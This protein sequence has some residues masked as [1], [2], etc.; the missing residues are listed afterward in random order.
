[1]RGGGFRL[2]R[3]GFFVSADGPVVPLHGGVYV[4]Q[5]EA[6]AILLGIQLQRQLVIVFGLPVFG[7]LGLEEGVS[8]LQ[9]VP[10]GSPVQFLK[11]GLL[12]LIRGGNWIA[13]ACA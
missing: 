13:R 10:R 9:V 2:E 11:R 6:G 3:D 8:R 1:M 5:S 12:V 7:R 4:P